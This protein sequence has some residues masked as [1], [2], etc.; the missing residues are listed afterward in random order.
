MEHSGLPDLTPSG[1]Y[2]ILNG[3]SARLKHD[4]GHRERPL[5]TMKFLNIQAE[6]DRVV[7]C[8]HQ[9]LLGAKV[10]LRGLHGG[11]AQQ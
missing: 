2:P 1:A 7:W 6:L 10:S 8:M 3:V 11:V 4:D 5:R 9:V